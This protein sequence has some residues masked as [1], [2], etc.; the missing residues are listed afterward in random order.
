MRELC[1]VYY[2]SRDMDAKKLMTLLKLLPC[3]KKRKGN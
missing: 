1:E 3:V 2:V